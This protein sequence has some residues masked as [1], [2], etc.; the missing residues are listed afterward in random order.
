[1]VKIVFRVK[2]RYKMTYYTYD[3]ST[4]KKMNDSGYLD[5]SATGVG[6]GQIRPPTS[7]FL[8]VFE[9]T[10]DHFFGT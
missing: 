5:G 6:R 3:G 1:M 8:E 2:N 4:W 10:S 7:E 9:I